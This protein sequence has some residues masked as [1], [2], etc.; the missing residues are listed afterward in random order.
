MTNINLKDQDKKC[1]LMAFQ[2][3]TK[4]GL[5]GRNIFQNA[6]CIMIRAHKQLKLKVREKS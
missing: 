5:C 4:T 6:V 1:I 3:L 2:S